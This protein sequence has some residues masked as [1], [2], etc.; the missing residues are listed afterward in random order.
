[1]SVFDSKAATWDDD[2][3]RARASA[4]AAAIGELVPLAEIH[5]MVE[6]GCG[7]G[8]LSLFFL[9]SPRVLRTRC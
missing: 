8:L 5:D 4:V 9:H 2:E 7:T 6:F 3:R 1:M